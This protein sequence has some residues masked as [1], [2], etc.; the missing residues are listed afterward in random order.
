MRTLFLLASALAAPLLYAQNNPL[1]FLNEPLSPA[2]ASPGAAAFTLTITGTGFVS[3][4]V[5]KWNS[6]PRTT[7]FVS[8]SELTAAVPASDIAKA[9]TAVVTVFNPQPHGGTSNGVFFQV[10]QR[11]SKVSLA[12]AASYSLSGYAYPGI[13][14]VSDLRGNGIQDLIISEYG[15][16]AVMLGNGDGT[17]QPAVTYPITSGGSGASG[18]LAIADFNKDGHPD[19]AVLGDNNGT[20]Y[21]LLGNGD[22]TLQPPAGYPSNTDTG[23]ASAIAVGDFNGDGHLDVVAAVAYGSNTDLYLLVFLGKSD[24]TFEKPK[25]TSYSLGLASMVAGDFNGDGMLDLALANS[26]GLYVLPGNGDGT[27]GYLPPV[28]Y[29]Y[30]GLAAA[31]LNGDG[32]LDLVGFGCSVVTFGQNNCPNEPVQVYTLLGNGDGTFTEN[33]HYTVGQYTQSL[34]VGDFNN[35][36][37][38]DIAL[39]DNALNCSTEFCNWPTAGIAVMPG[40]GDGTFAEPQIMAGQDSMFGMVAA[41][42]NGDGKLDVAA[43]VGTTPSFGSDVPDTVTVN[44]Q[45]SADV[46]PGLLSFGPALV[47]S[48][49]TGKVTFTNLGKTALNISQV[50]ISGPDAPEFAIT[51]DGCQGAPVAPSGNCTVNLSFTASADNTQSAFLTFTDNA[52]VSQQT[53]ALTG[54]GT[55]FETAPTAIDFGDVKVGSVSAQRTIIVTNTGTT[56]GNVAI[57][58]VGAQAG[59]FIESTTCPTTLSAGASCVVTVQFA[60]VRSGSQAGGVYVNA[61][62]GGPPF[63]PAKVALTGT[64]N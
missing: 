11:E 4:S 59:S 5:V 19:V 9:K 27:F 42:F 41:D 47:G 55:Y 58:V 57:S 51:G 56:G 62:A 38:M 50:D 18:A 7:T 34:L 43:L 25:E 15:D 37:R 44:L 36:G 63:S 39:A 22:G 16:V 24:G 2:S 46:S 26:S 8:S 23:A 21:I 17:F 10:A 20:L 3:G 14:C 31:D 48:S 6:S 61:Y 53:A 13:V 28:P 52:S 1:P 35:D 29:A 54:N 30:Y 12:T 32:I 64:G 33:G 40:K 49:A 60:P 45:D